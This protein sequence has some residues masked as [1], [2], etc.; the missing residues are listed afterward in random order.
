[1]Q[2]FNTHKGA[3]GITQHHHFD[4][5]GSAFDLFEVGPVENVVHRCLG[6]R[7]FQFEGRHEVATLSS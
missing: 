4:V 1:M 6:A 2:R 5:G 7:I 3:T